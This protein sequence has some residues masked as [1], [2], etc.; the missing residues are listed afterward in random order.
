MLN[1]NF[2]SFSSL[3]TSIETAK[4]TTQ[5]AVSRVVGV[6]DGSHPALLHSRP[7]I[8]TRPEQPQEYRPCSNEDNRWERLLLLVL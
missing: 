4:A 7:G 1:L 8:E 2:L 3:L 5:L 6:D